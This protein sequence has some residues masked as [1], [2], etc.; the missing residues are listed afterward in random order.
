LVKLF[1]V[2]NAKRNRNAKRKE[3]TDDAGNFSAGFHIISHVV[4]SFK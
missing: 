1:A 2:D 3:A 4:V